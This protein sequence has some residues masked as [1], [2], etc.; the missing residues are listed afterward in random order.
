[1]YM[2]NVYKYI[3]ARI[4]KAAIQGRPSK[5]KRK[6]PCSFVGKEKKGSLKEG[7]PCQP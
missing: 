1:M 3:L 4:T 6:Q 2:Y 7:E 5:K